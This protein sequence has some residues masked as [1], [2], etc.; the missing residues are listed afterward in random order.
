MK[1]RSLILVGLMA[2]SG[3]GVAH[4]QQQQQPGNSLSGFFRA[5]MPG[6]AAQYEYLQAVDAYK[7]CIATKPSTA[8]EGQR[9]VMDTAAAVAGQPS[10]NIYV[11]R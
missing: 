9:H 10:T 4:A 8:C 11:G 5:L 6:R 7:Q 2:S 1:T 3:F